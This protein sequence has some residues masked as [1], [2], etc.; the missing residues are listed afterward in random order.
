MQKKGKTK[1]KR[2]HTLILGR[3]IFIKAEYTS[4]VAITRINH[5]I[6]FKK[7]EVCMG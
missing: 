3:T 4:L 1:I 5:H 6:E 7:K 2:N